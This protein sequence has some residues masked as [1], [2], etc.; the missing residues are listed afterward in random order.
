LKLIASLSLR[1]R[2]I[3]LPSFLLDVDLNAQHLFLASSTGAV[4]DTIM[5]RPTPTPRLNIPAY[6]SASFFTV[7]GD[8]SSPYPP[9]SPSIADSDDDASTTS[10][11]GLRTSIATL[12]EAKL[13]A[14][15]IKLADSNPRF[16]RAI[17]KEVAYA[18]TFDESSPTTPT[19]HKMRKSHR[20]RPRP[21]R[22][23]TSAAPCSRKRKVIPTHVACEAEY[24]YHPGMWINLRSRHTLLIIS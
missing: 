22:K 24:V 23:D 11:A 7:N 18:Q 8:S 3:N 6:K 4:Q 14:I 21:S 20:P 10:T 17:A 2:I 16:Q 13:R 5:P 9:S 19:N 1:S 12:S 15:L